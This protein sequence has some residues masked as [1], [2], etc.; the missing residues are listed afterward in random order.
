M[1]LSKG[2]KE[3][4]IGD[5]VVV[6]ALC[7]T[8]VRFWD[9]DLVVVGESEAEAAVALVAPE[10]DRQPLASLRHTHL[11]LLPH[12]LFLLLRF[13]LAQVGPAHGHDGAE[14]APPDHPK[15]TCWRA[16]LLSAAAELQRHRRT[17]NTRCGRHHAQLHTHFV[18]ALS[19][20]EPL[21]WLPRALPL[22][23]RPLPA[24]EPQRHLVGR[25]TRV[26]FLSGLVEGWN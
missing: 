24:C 11:L 26:R 9:V 14:G 5:A 10:R 15:R 4:A 1:R 25:V 7:W 23:R 6:R 22:V 20:L 19:H 13:L 18:P 21:E 17:R 12:P 16:D 3:A 8:R 2:E